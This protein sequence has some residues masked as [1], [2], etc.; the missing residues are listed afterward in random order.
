MVATLR[1]VAA[2]AGVHP[3]T[4]SRAMNPDTVSLVNA[5]TAQRIKKAALKLGYV[6]NPVA[7]SLK[8]NRTSSVAVLIPDLTNPLFPPIVRGIEDVL[9]TAGYTALLANT[10]S[11]M[12]KEAR[13]AAAMRSRQVDGFIIATALLE[14]PL[15]EQLVAESVPIVF[16][17]RRVEGLPASAV[18]GDDATGVAAAVDHLAR[19]GH[20][21]IAYIAG[22]QTTST[23]VVRLQAFRAAMQRWEL[24]IVE[25][26]IASSSHFQEFDG[27][28]AAKYLFECGRPFTAIIAGNDLL[29]L[30]CYDELAARGLR[31]PEDISVVGFNDMP[32]V[33]KFNPPLT[34]VHVPLY[35][36]GAEAARMLLG[37]LDGSDAG[38]KSVLLPVRLEVRGSTAPPRL[39]GS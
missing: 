18:A 20:R 4:V 12:A 37:R 36:I 26:L 9:A 39:A 8:T 38:E 31:C 34:T 29:A 5:A 30:G 10:D 25:E 19:L 15:M 6:V 11:D 17:N 3:A 33:D 28:T 2:L 1:D 7:R 23:G 24:P 22:P 27:V 21:H 14:H 16:V 35:E 13:Q 32:F